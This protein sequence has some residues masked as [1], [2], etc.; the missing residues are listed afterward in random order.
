M[1]DKRPLVIWRLLDGKPGHE[2][3]SFGLLQ[4]LAELTSI[5]AF[6]FDT[7]FPALL[8]RQL[9]RGLGKR[10]G[11]MPAPDLL[12]GVGHQTHVSMLTSRALRGG[13]TVLLMKPSLPPHLFDLVFVPQHDR[14]RARDNVVETRGVICPTSIDAK[15]PTEGLILVGGINK[16]FKWSNETIAADIVR[17]ASAH[18]ETHWSICDSRRTPADFPTAIPPIANATYH[19]WQETPGDFLARRMA[20]S[21]RAWVTSDSVSMLYEALSAGA[22]VGVIDLP[23]HDA[24]KS[25]KHSRGINR[26]KGDRL[27]LASTDGLDL[28]TFD[29]APFVAENR[30]CAAIVLD[31]LFADRDHT[32]LPQ[33][34]ATARRSA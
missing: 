3:Q 19:P 22:R 5:E 32:S 34:F 28:D 8:R 14:F 10:P 27:V 25:Y 24:R 11:D 31:R 9:R 17:I 7:R 21:V 1:N 29:P 4:G 33:A 2:K 18:P 6:E 30:R 23:L 12:L 20:R 16:T 15:D 26:L 13:K